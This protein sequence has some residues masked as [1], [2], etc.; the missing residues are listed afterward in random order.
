[1]KSIM[2]LLTLSNI[3]ALVLVIYVVSGMMPSMTQAAFLTSPTGYFLLFVIFVL[4]MRFVNP[5]VVVILLIALYESIRRSHIKLQ[6]SFD[7]RLPSESTRSE[8]MDKVDYFPET[9]EEDVIAESVKPVDYGTKDNSKFVG[10]EDS[11][12]D[13]SD[14]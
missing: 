2:K 12:M 6:K 1:M 13:Y 14:V 7:Y 4:S 10:I 8:Y 5:I 11:K 3:V 9:L